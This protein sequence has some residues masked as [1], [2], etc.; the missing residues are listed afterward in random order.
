MRLTSIR[1]NL[2]F[3]KIAGIFT[4]LLII[5][6]IAYMGIAAWTAK[7]SFNEINQQLYGDIA[8]HLS[9]STKPL[10]DGKVDTVVTHDIIH[11]IMVINPSVEVYLLDP[12]G[13]IIDYVVPDKSVK[14]RAVDLG[15]IRQYIQ[16][17]GKKYVGGDNPKHPGQKSIFSAAPIYE[18]NKLTGYVYAILASEKQAEVVAALDKDFFYS[19]GTA[20][21]C[22][23]LLTVFIV[24]IITF[25]L[26]TDSV[27]KV[28]AIV[29]RFKEGDYGARIDGYVEG[30][31][32]LLT[33]T[34]NEMADTIVD[35]MNKITS[36][37]K[38]R[39]ELIAN[40]S[41]DLRS[42]LSIMQGYIETLII[43]KDSLPDAEKE[44]YLAVI[45]RSSRKLSHL[46][47]QLFEYSKLEAN[48]V[49]PDKEQFLID[50]LVSDILM[51]YEIPA[52]AKGIKLSME[53]PGKLPAV[54]AD[55]S[56]VERAIQNLVDNALR[57]TPERGKITIAL[58]N[59][60]TGIE[61]SVADTGPGIPLEDQPYVFE[62]YKKLSGNETANHE[63]TGLGLA[64]VKKILELHQSGIHIKSTPGMGTI[65][66]FQLPTP[67]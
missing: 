48:Q 43:K 15:A 4:L 14:E 52:K 8:A 40:V 58:Q 18:H 67:G 44:R 66:W 56:L 22:A 31:L 3:W 50:E 65:F 41:H 29:K 59:K 49:Q 9:N 55:I 47:G 7:R 1:G 24:G 26:I 32:G 21:F 28:A 23:T 12:D 36:L 11:S 38:L 42:P 34:F 51:K 16:E 63:G 13:K 46:V 37:D 25:F 45:M 5:L 33:S 57:F 27:G 61:V 60:T 6:G 2:L 53:S 10:K 20:I 64:I 54:F 17:G 19:L 39:Q 30:N 35:N 62:R